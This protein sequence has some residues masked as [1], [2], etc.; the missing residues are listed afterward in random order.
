MLRF[1]SCLAHGPAHAAD[2][3]RWS[4]RAFLQRLGV[5]T[6][7][8][9]FLGQTPVRAY[10]HSSWLDRLRALETSRVLVLVQLGGGN[11]GLNTVVPVENDL[12][13]NARPTLSIAKNA[14]LDLTDELG[15][16]PSMAPLMDRYQRGH[17]AIL[18]NVGYAAPDLS[19]FR[20][21]DI[22]VSGSDAAT[23]ESTGW[24]GRYLH[25]TYPTF[26]ESPPD[27]PL[28]VQL[29]GG[30]PMLL[31]GPSASM[32]MSILSTE[33]FERLASTGLLYETANVPATVYGSEMQFVRDIAN[34][35]FQYAGAVQEAAARGPNSVAYPANNALARDLA[36][37]AQLIKGRLG[38]RIYAV[39]L[40]GF[41]TH[42]NQANTH[43]ALLGSLAAAIQAF[44]DDLAASNMGQEVLVM[45]FSEFGRR[46]QQNGTEGTDHG[47][48]APLFLLGEGLN[49]GLYGTAPDLANLDNTGN[50]AFETD[51]RAIYYTLL[52]DWFGM[53]PQQAT[54]TLGA[55]FAPLPFV[56]APTGVGSE[57]P[58]VPASF[59]LHP[60]YPN[61][62]NPE[63]ILSYQLHRTLHVRL[64][65]FDAQGRLVQTLV[66]EPQV[67]GLHAEPFYAGPLPSGPYFYRLTTPDGTQT[68][69]MMLV[70]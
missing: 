21:T 58:A 36:V 6:G 69:Q 27:Y 45:T 4:R 5:A 17:M 33:L 54:E 3:A 34:D 59:R 67:A 28:A 55:S 15:L 52:Q 50:L 31:Q 14:T 25:E 20:S 24:T 32:G 51:F 35:T 2:H 37:V 63:T 68:R 30:A 13:Y 26:A 66:D 70:K 56:A 10:G 48:A 40:G 62:F 39:S 8:L 46:V 11:D 22:W 38:A 16:H 12:Y 23:V 43:S 53:D 60:N 64:E 29:G 18:Q 1:G 7:G 57:P 41:D 44:L 65:V 19:H 47:T 61:P 9:F 42:A 49:G